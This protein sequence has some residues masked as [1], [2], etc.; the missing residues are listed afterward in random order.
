MLYAIEY[1]VVRLSPAVEPSA[2][3][4][5][6]EPSPSMNRVRPS[7]AAI[8]PTA[9]AAV[10]PSAGVI[11]PSTAMPSTPAVEPSAAAIDPRR[12]FARSHGAK[13][14]SANYGHRPFAQ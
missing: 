1:I 3:A 9:A 6:I 11:G 8:C 5:T 14:N 4:A 13:N 12:P 2:A 7:A 10:E